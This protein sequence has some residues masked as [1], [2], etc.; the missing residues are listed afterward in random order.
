LSFHF[1]ILTICLPLLLTSLSSG[2]GDC[3]SLLGGMV[4]SPRLCYRKQRVFLCSDT[5]LTQPHPQARPLTQ[6]LLLLT[7]RRTQIVLLFPY[8]EICTHRSLHT[9]P[10]S[11][12]IGKSE[13][14]TSQ[15]KGRSL[16]SRIPETRWPVNADLFPL[17]FGTSLIVIS[18]LAISST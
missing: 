8:R 14:A 16:G 6:D 2:S 13:L 18:P 3:L 12:L 10:L 11:L 15:F 17:L 1:W 7:A 4:N 9:I 5:T